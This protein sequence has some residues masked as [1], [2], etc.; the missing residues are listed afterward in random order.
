[1]E[2]LPD[3][4]RRILL[5]LAAGSWVAALPVSLRAMDRD[6]KKVGVLGRG[7]GGTFTS[8]QEVFP[9]SFGALGFEKGRNLDLRLY[10][11]EMPP[12]KAEHATPEEWIPIWRAVDARMMSDQLDCIVTN[13]E[14]ATRYLLEQTQSIP[15]VTNVS[16]PV[17]LGVAKSLGRPG[18]NVT[19]V[20]S[21][22]ADVAVKTVELF[23]R[24]VP[25]LKSVGWVGWP[26]F[27]A[28]AKALES[29]ARSLGLGFH[30]VLVESLDARGAEK[31]RGEVAR[32]RAQG[33]L[34]AAVLI[35]YDEGTKAIFSQALESRIA[36]TGGNPN[37]DGHLLSYGARWTK[38]QEP[39]QR[40]PAIAARIL[41]GEKPADIPFEGPNEYELVV[42]MRTAAMIGIA[43]PP[44]VQLLA[45]RLIR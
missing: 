26:P 42:N 34:A 11:V 16:D 20:H 31:A 15:I 12:E 13:G 39:D 35:P 40:I 41:H 36:L 43:V 5:S 18:G 45:T 1:M 8:W 6:A 17:S 19:G 27:L 9:K 2:A 38:G 3:R 33:I 10:G 22:D 30:P 25:G 23:R 24:L 44:D 32:F 28:G 4:R 14:P 7:S 29:A 21:G 37:R